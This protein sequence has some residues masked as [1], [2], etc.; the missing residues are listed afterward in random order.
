VKIPLPGVTPVPGYG[1]TKGM[2]QMTPTPKESK[3][4]HYRLYT[5]DKTDYVVA[6]PSP[7]RALRM[8]VN[9]AGLTLESQDGRYGK[10]TDGTSV[11]AMTCQ[12]S[13]AHYS[14]HGT[15]RV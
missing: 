6:A 11:S 1:D 2:T 3:M 5:E 7:A 12:W 14:D 13:R 10:T 8:L 9:A 15:T 4:R